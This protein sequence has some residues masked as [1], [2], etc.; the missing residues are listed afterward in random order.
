[1]E[2]K[3]KKGVLVRDDRLRLFMERVGDPLGAE[4]GALTG[5]WEHPSDEELDEERTQLEFDAMYLLARSDRALAMRDIRADEVI[6]RLKRNNAKLR[7][8]RDKMRVK[9]VKLRGDVKTLQRRRL[10]HRVG[11]LVLNV[12][13]RFRRLRRGKG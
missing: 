7:K 6:S 8:R 4:G 1:M 5:V 13:R 2:R 10:R 11:M 3:L 9:V 12:R